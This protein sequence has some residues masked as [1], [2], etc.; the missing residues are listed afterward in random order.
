MVTN[1]HPRRSSATLGGCWESGR[2]ADAVTDLSIGDAFLGGDELRRGQRSAKL[3]ERA[4]HEALRDDPTVQRI[5]R[6]GLP[7]DLALQPARGRRKV[8]LELGAERVTLGAQ[9]D[10]AAPIL[11]GRRGCGTRRRSRARV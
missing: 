7:P 8:A 1:P 11:I 10:D 4:Q 6:G 2:I 5:E 9:F 3:V